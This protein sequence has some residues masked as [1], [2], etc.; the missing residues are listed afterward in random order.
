MDAVTDADAICVLLRQSF[1]LTIHPATLRQWASRGH[2]SR[3]GRDPVY[4][5]TRYRIAEVLAHATKGVPRGG[6]TA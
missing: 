2:I 3:Y 6:G 1:G 4:H 5:R